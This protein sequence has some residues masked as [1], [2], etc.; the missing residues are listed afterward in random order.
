MPR[1][2]S[3]H[4]DVRRVR[5][6]ARHD[7]AGTPDQ[8]ADAAPNEERRRD[9]PPVPLGDPD[10]AAGPAGVGG[11][12]RGTPDAD[13][14]LAASGGVVLRSTAFVDHELIPSRHTDP[15]GAVSPP[16]E[17][18]RV[19]DGAAEF[20]L[21][22]EDADAAR[23]VHWVVA[24]IPPSVSGLP[25]GR[26]PDG[27]V[28]GRND[29]GALG[30]TPPRPPLGDDPHRYLFRLLALDEPLGLEQGVTADRLRTSAKGHQ[31]A[32]GTLVGVFAR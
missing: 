18:T 24:G 29:S 5:L 19:P 23:F 25:E 27:A 4:H 15:T 9:Q 8:H 26:L 3:H 32:T 20:A 11:D 21:T 6:R 10:R 28:E 31:L 22:C 2:G 13:D 12:S 17:W 30:W 7:D 1:P 14:P 16:L